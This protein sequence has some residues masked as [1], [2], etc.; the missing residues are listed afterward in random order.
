[1]KRDWK[2]INNRLVGHGTLLLSV[3]FLENWGKQLV[4][5][6][7]GKVGSPFR[8]P[9]GLMEY[10]GLLHC[11]L[12]L[13]YRQVKGVFIA[14]NKQE[15]RLKVP[16]YSQICRR[17]NKLPVKINPKKSISQEKD[18]FIAIDAS[19]ESVTNR[20]EWLRK[21]HR[22]GKIGECKGFIKIHVAVN[23]EN[24]EL[25]EMKI[26]KE[27]IGDNRE[28]RNLLNE[29]IEN[30][31]KPIMQVNADSGYDSEN[32]FEML[33]EMG[34]N[35]IIRIKDNADVKPPPKDFIHRNRPEPARKKHARIQLADREKWKKKNKYG[36]RWIVETFFSSFKRRFG[37]YVTARKWINM[38]QE[39]RF[40]AQLHNQLL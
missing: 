7:S 4:E 30:T 34:I 1:M 5:L 39:L 20:G 2:S 10:A 15:S 17:F 40:K 27:N 3:D 26:T 13:G 11:Y 9:L 18:L 25:L 38:K 36:L 14:I 29:C 8:Y 24:N 16:A 31:G 37:T 21:I 22:K 12:R 32:N 19:G 28:F 23:I 35:P 33:E 6:N